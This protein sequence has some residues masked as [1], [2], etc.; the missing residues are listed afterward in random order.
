MEENWTKLEGNFLQNVK[1]IR[2]FF[3]KLKE[4]PQNWKNFPENWGTKS[5]KKRKFPQ[6]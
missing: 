4:I 3:W 6:N 2:D 1:E 5:W